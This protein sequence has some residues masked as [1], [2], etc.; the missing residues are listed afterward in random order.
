MQAKIT[1]V[2]QYEAYER[3]IICKE[4]KKFQLF[5]A[6]DAGRVNLQCLYTITKVL[7]VFY[8]KEVIKTTLLWA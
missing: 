7:Q 1:L 5:N 4:V 3:A 6:S 2:N 8:Q